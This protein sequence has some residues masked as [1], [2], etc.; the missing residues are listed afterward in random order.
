MKDGRPEE[1]AKLASAVVEGLLDGPGMMRLLE[2][3]RND[4]AL[5]KRFMN[6]VD[7]DRLLEMALRD[8]SGISF[9]REVVEKIGWDGEPGKETEFVKPVMER[10]VKASVFRRSARRWAAAG[11][12][13]MAL[14]GMGLMFVGRQPPAWIHRD[15]A[16]TWTGDEPAEKLKPGA[17]LRLAGGLAEIHFRNGAEL[18]LEGPADL[19]IL[20]PG[21]GW[22]HKGKAAVDV[23]EKAIGFTLDS[24]GGRVIDL[25]TSFG[26]A[27]GDDGTTE[28]QVFEGKVKVRPLGRKSGLILREN[29]TFAMGREGKGRSGGAREGTFVTG[30][31][32]RAAER[33]DFV[34]WSMDERKG[35]LVTTFRRGKV[36]DPV[37]AELRA[38]DVDGRMPEWIEGPFGGALSFDG[39][40]Q[41]LE[42]FHDGPAGDAARTIAFWVR[43][44]EDFDPG[45]GFGIISWGKL[46][47]AGMAWQISAHPY[48]EEARTGRLRVGIG[49]SEVVG[50]TDLR[51]GNWHHCAVV[52]YRDKRR[53]DRFP[54]LLYVDGKME[55]ALNKAVYGVRTG[56]GS[57]ARKI[58]IG[59]SLGHGRRDRPYKGTG[60]F[61][62]DLDEVYVFEGSLNLKQIQELMKFNR[63]PGEGE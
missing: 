5:R 25:G 30:H 51:D 60:F 7:V 41:A 3:C 13:A 27:V 38:F 40:G 49:Y 23:P 62:G 52:M 1:F 15:D 59:R 48:E 46:P 4:E 45:Q 10:I 35:E 31:P 22:L 2:L 18:I 57:D 24:P 8:A 6:L 11:I 54:V 43:V 53:P 29:E 36:T 61:R 16:A 34:H 19:E 58:W 9:S 44:P 33:M 47:D 14:L 39:R 28:T 42:T 55:A 20:G 17:R 26:V 56:A 37:P 50:V 12:A 63:P 21:A 32:P